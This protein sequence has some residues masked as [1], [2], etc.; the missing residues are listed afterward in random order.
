MKGNQ[1]YGVIKVAKTPTKKG[2]PC[3][4]NYNSI[5]KLCKLEDGF[6]FTLRAKNKKG[7]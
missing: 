1:S 6:T 2:K 5:E 4:C 7:S 3:D